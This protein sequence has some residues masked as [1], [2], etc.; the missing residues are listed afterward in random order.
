MRSCALRSLHT[1]GTDS[2]GKGRAPCG[3]GARALRTNVGD[4]IGLAV[5]GGQNKPVVGGSDPPHFEYSRPRLLP[6]LSGLPPARGRGPPFRQT[7]P[8]PAARRFRLSSDDPRPHPH[9]A[10]SGRPG[11][12]LRHFGCGG[13]NPQ[14]PRQHEAPPGPLPHPATPRH[15]LECLEIEAEG[16][17]SHHFAQAI[18]RPP[19]AAPDNPSPRPR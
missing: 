16:R 6:R 15:C 9:R 5:A 11:R 3:L 7:P 2:S 18:G 19:P 4:N 14:G 10:S 1:R 17:L 12:S 13:T 8:T